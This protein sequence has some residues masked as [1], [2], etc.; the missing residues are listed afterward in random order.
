[1]I[2]PDTFLFDLDGTVVNTIQYHKMTWIYILGVLGLNNIDYDLDSIIHYQSIDVLKVILG[3]SIAYYNLEEIVSKKN[4]MFL[5]LINNK[6]ILAVGILKFLHCLK[7]SGKKTALISSSNKD[8]VYEIL[9]RTNLIGLFDV[10]ISENDVKCGKPNPECYFLA[11]KRL[12]SSSKKAIAFE[13]SSTGISSARGALI[14]TIKVALNYEEMEK[15]SPDTIFTINN[16]EEELI[17]N[18]L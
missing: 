10:I 3:D 17:Y 15:G 16:F 4:S 12:D 13:D 1:M 7:N 8:I 11:L 5:E 6:P 18:L 14:A 2:K 9:H